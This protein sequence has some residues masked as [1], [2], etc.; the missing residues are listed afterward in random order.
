MLQ[1][2]HLIPATVGCCLKERPPVNGQRPV[3]SLAVFV[4]SLSF[5][6]AC[7]APASAQQRALDT[8]RSTMAVRVFKSGLLGAFGD[9]HVILA[10]LTEGSVEESSTPYVEF[11]VDASQMR[12][13]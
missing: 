2:R 13:L 1:A 9:N 4:S 7:P 12:V 3:A 5:V 10:P 8:V 6:L 11:V